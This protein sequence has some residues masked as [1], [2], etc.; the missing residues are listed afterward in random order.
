MFQ[1]YHWVHLVHHEQPIDL[2]KDDDNAFDDID[3][4]IFFVATDDLTKFMN[5]KKD[6]ELL[7]IQTKNAANEMRAKW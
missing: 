4:K 2:I 1:N 7:T 3:I 6:W 5:Y